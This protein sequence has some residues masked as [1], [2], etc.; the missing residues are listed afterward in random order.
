MRF[1]KAAMIAHPSK[2]L[3]PADAD[4]F[5]REL[6]AVRER[7]LADLGQRD[8]DHIRGV[9]RMV[10]YGELAGRALLHAGIDPLTFALG[11][12]ALGTSKILE[13]MEVGHNVM[14]GQY[15]WTG[16]PELDSKSYEWDLAAD[17]DHWRRSHNV[18]H[19]VFTNI[20]GRD[21]DIGYGFLRVSSLQPRLPQHVLQPFVVV[22][23]ALLFQWGIAFHDL[24]LDEL[25]AG[26]QSFAV[27]RRRAAPILRKA[28]WQLA[29]DYLVFPAL[30]LWNAPR[31]AVGNLFA[32]GIRNLWTFAI[33][34]CGHFPD[35]V[36]WYHPEETRDERRGDWYLRQLNSSANIAGRRGFHV[37]SGHLGYQIEHH[38]F[39]DLPAARYPEI[40]AHVREIC[41]RYGQAYNTGPFSVQLASV[42]RLLVGNAF[43]A[44]APRW[45]TRA[46]D[47]VLLRARGRRSKP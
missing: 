25:L 12:A 31:V 14:H 5:G 20:L 9:I 34:F 22:W 39:P 1:G 29:K 15:D 19:H 17:G 35:G 28:G 18:E 10:R 8:V 2:P 44:A 6:D 16:D 40:A 7:V 24:H 11:V 32:N 23:L 41:A 36:R 38:L 4:S 13:N 45:F 37:L 43:P 47:R 3:S 33:I 26:R 42:A 27:F 30:A 46:A 21:R